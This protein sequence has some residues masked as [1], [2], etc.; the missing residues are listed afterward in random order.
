MLGELACTKAGVAMCKQQ[1]EPEAPEVQCP[2]EH[3][4]LRSKCTVLHFKL[5]I[6]QV[7]LTLEVP[8]QALDLRLAQPLVV[9]PLPG[10][11]RK[12]GQV[13]G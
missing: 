12:Q 11:A 5:P 3:G 6:W 2:C 9:A 4:A 13:H 7:R 8:H 10:T 1:C